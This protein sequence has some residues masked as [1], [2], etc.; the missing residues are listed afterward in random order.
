MNTIIK[1][2]GISVD[3]SIHSAI[4]HA[5][6]AAKHCI[7]NA[8][9]DVQDISYLLNVGIYRDQ[10]I[11]EPS[12]GALIQKGIGLNPDFLRFPVDSTAFS[13]DLM[14]GASGALNAMQVADALFKTGLKGYVLVVSS[15]AHPSGEPADGFPVQPAGAAFLLAPSEEKGGFQH[16]QFH[17]TQD[18]YIG[19][20]SYVDFKKHGTEASHTITI[21]T[22]ENFYRDLKQFAVDKA[23]QFIHE[24][25]VDLNQTAIVAPAFDAEFA[26]DVAREV[27]ATQDKIVDVWEK[28][29]NPHTSTFGI[30]YHLLQESQKHK[31]C[32]QVLFIGAG[33][34]LSTSCALYQCA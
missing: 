11:V 21:D 20:S 4:E 17:D 28:C 3:P 25:H 2:T 22:D 24:N 9:I 33:A 23:R 29:G 13:T 12:I 34:G 6:R 5:V 15:D 32:R 7:E 10:N 27:G 26:N 1:A 30:G 16:F 19:Q 18:A 31:D 14:N 8:G